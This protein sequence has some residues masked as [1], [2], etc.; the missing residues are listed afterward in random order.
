L[1]QAEKVLILDALR[2]QEGNRLAAAK[3]LGIA[4]STLFRKIKLHRIQL[5]KK[6]GRNS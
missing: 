5:P 3:E 2:R 1:K 4:P 6:D